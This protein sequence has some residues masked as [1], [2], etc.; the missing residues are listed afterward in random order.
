MLPTVLAAMPE[1]Y[2]RYIEPM[3]GS[4][5]LFFAARPPAVACSVTSDP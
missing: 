5:C 1:D 3:V 2:G 4:A